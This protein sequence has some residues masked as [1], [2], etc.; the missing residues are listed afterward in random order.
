MSTTAKDYIVL[1]ATAKPF[2]NLLWGGTLLMGLGLCLSIRQRRTA[3][4]AKVTA[5]AT[6]RAGAARPQA[7]A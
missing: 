3:K 2:I 7:V 4:A 5:P 6:G 1:K